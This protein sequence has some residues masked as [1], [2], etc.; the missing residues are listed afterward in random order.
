MIIPPGIG[1]HKEDRFKF[2]QLRLKRHQPVV[3]IMKLPDIC[4]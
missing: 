3:R 4:Q 1:L 2:V